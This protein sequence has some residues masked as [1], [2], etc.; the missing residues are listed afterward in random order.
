MLNKRVR[1][2]RF[3]NAK[4]FPWRAAESFGLGVSLPKT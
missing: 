2:M 4:M 1:R 3:G